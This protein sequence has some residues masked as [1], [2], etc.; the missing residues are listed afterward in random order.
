MVELQVALLGTVN[1]MAMV[2]LWPLA[3]V[4]LLQ[5]TFEPF[6]AQLESEDPLLNVRPAGTGSATLTVCAV[7]GPA[8]DI[9]T[10]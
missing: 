8:L 9:T 10:V 5:S 2:L 3:S 1:A 7:P 6:K 4:M